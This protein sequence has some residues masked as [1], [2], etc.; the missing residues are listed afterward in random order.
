M[1]HL[2]ITL[3]ILFRVAAVFGVIGLIVFLVWGVLYLALY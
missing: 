2:K 1:K 3:L